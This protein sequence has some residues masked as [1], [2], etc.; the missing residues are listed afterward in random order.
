MALW[1]HGVVI[2][3]NIF[4]DYLRKQ[5]TST[6]TA[7]T[8]AC[9]QQDTIKTYFIDSDNRCL[10]LQRQV[11]QGG[12]GTIKGSRIPF[13]WK[14]LLCR[15][16]SYCEATIPLPSPPATRWHPADEAS[17]GWIPTPLCYKHSQREGDPLFLVVD[18]KE[19]MNWTL[20]THG[21]IFCVLSNNDHALLARRRNELLEAPRSSK[22]VWHGKK[23]LVR[24]FWCGGSLDPNSNLN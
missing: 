11:H 15:S 4:Y 10:Y 19:C 12:L 1:Q 5:P 14:R 22:C 3:G 20:A 17:S 21:E 2:Y 23:C 13:L 8:G 9:N 18:H 7:T 24:G 6:T 16:A